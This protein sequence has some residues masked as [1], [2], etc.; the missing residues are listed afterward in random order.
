LSKW[1]VPAQSL[2]YKSKR[3]RLQDTKD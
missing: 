2:F 3:K 1:T